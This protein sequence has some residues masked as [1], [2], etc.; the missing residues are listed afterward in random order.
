MSSKFKLVTSYGSVYK[1][2]T[3]QWLNY[4]DHRSNGGSFDVSHF[5]GKSLGPVTDITEWTGFDA[6]AERGALLAK[7]ARGA[8]S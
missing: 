3:Q 6:Q 5:G 8:R 2:T 7:G 4:V 1:L